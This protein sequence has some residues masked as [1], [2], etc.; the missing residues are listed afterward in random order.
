MPKN[1]QNT[2]TDFIVR[3][4]DKSNSP[5]VF[6]SADR[7]IAAQ[8]MTVRKHAAVMNGTAQNFTLWQRD[9]CYAEYD[10]VPK[11]ADGIG[12]KGDVTE[13]RIS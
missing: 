3:A 10:T 12:A 13:E 7:E 4:G 9:V 1:S 11:G 8:E 5:A 2:A 6:S